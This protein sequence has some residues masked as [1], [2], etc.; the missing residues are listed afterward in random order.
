MDQGRPPKYKAEFA[1][2]AEKLCALGAVDQE[3]A[4]FFD[5]EIRT[6]Y[7]WK[8]E[9]PD[10]ASALTVG[11]N[12][13]DER[14][15]RSLYQRAIGYE[16]DEVKIF[17]PAM[18]NKPVYAPYRAKI[19]ADVGAIKL[20]LINRRGEDWQEKREVYYKDTTDPLTKAERDERARQVVQARRTVYIP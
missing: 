17:M 4:D 15:V 6:I 20:W 8:L 18:A 2:Q 11:K 12:H 1:K 10:F 3:I 9:H 5:V 14:V 19:A 16:Q 7:R 13:A